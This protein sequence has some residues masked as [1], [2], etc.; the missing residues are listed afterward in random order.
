MS[1]EVQARGID[2][3]AGHQLERAILDAIDF[4]VTLE[5]LSS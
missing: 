2:E 4:A 5:R 3:P 1:N